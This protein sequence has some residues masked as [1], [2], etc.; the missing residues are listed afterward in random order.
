MRFLWSNSSRKSF[1]DW[2]C[3]KTKYNL[4]QGNDYSC[5]FLEGSDFTAS[6]FPTTFSWSAKPSPR[7]GIATC[8]FPKM[9]QT[10]LWGKFEKSIIWKGKNEQKCI[11]FPV[12]IHSKKQS[13]PWKRWETI[14]IFHTTSIT[15]PLKISGL[16][17]AFSP[18]RKSRLWHPP[19]ATSASNQQIQ[20]VA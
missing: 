8:K 6:G 13:I 20:T 14:F 7:L 15:N 4:L 17:A 11:D 3:R 9:F 5:H 1:W 18:P 19:A 16:A 2:K 10:T 12:D